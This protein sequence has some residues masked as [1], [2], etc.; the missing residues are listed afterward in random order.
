MPEAAPNSTDR[1]LSAASGMAV[2]VADGADR[3]V[4]IICQFVVLVTGIALLLILTSNV[5]ARY[6]LASGGFA[7][8]QEVPERLFPWLI[9]A[10]VALAVQRGGHMAVEAVLSRLDRQRARLLLLFGHAIIILSYAIL[11]WEA[12]Q[13]ADIVSIE[14]SPVL[15]L[16]SSHSYYALAIG[17]LAVIIGTFAQALRVAALGPEA[18]PVPN[19]E[20]QPA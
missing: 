17:C 20:E 14:R 2:A 13:V 3:V 19:P 11:C 15:G 4:S 16:P 5:L 18:M 6:V 12:V 8:A 10:G 1:R 9:M 7:W